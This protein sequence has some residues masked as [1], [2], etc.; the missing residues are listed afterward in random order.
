[1]LR[2]LTSES[3]KSLSLSLKSIDDIHGGDSLSAGVLSVGHGISD[4]VLKEHLEDTT[5]LLVDKTRDSLDT[6]SACKT[7]DGGLSDTLDI[8]SQDLAMTLGATLSQSLSSFSS[9]RHDY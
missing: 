2:N 3:V 4:D 9:A 8:V 1:M 6:T 5:G 7:S